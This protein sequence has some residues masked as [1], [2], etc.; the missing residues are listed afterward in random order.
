M[1]SKKL[2]ELRKIAVITGIKFFF[3]FNFNLNNID[4]QSS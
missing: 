4:K 3:F 1:R 2:S